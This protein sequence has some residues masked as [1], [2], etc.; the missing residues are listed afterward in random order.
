MDL[1]VMSTADLHESSYLIFQQQVSQWIRKEE[2]KHE[3]RL[4]H[5][6]GKGEK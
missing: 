2:K 1:L 4:E 5:R 3:N 6:N